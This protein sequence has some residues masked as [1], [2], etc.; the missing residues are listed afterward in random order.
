MI[1]IPSSG[2]FKW[3]WS[4]SDDAEQV[5]S[6]TY[7]SLFT[8]MK[9]HEAA[10]RKRS[11]QGHYWWELR[12]CAYWERFNEPKIY[13]QLI[14]Y[15][16]CY[17]LDTTGMYGNNKTAFIL[18]G[19]PYLLAVLNSPLAWWY[20]W[21][22]LPHM[23][24]EALAPNPT[25]LRNLPIAQPTEQL[26]AT[27]ED[28][29]CSLVEWNTQHRQV[30]QTI[31]DW[32]RVEYEIEKPSRKLELPTDLDSDEFVTE[33]KRLRGRKNPLSAAGLR[34]LRDEHARTIEPARRQAAEALQLERQLGD[35]VN[36]AYGLSTEEV[37]L[38]W[39]TA[40]P[41]MPYLLE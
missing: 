28:R 2:D 30:S 33:V 16:P 12:S 31:Q 37:A 10:L 26:R 4:D 29:V 40:P 7:P 8:H 41:R 20:N 15:H 19:D 6:Q 38:M 25:V 14:Q 34:S 11:D 1:A 9:G 5:F 32:L 18:S 22:F 23:K 39:K 13:Y 36:E 27:I 24:D 3:P 35:L 21:R 17:A